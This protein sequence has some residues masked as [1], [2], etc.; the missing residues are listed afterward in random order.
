V[1]HRV[2]REGDLTA[3]GKDLNDASAALRAKARQR[4]TD[5][6]DRPDQIGCD[7]VF[8]L[9]V[10]EF[11]R[12]AEQPVASV[13]DDYVD[14][15]EPGESALDNFANRRSVGHVEHLSVER[16]GVTL[17]QIGNLAGIADSSDDAVAALEELIS[18]LT[19]EAATDSSDEPCALCHCEF[20]V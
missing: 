16:F 8:D 20:S 18:E 7:D 4:G 5:E 19:A 2:P 3:V 9:L 15:S 12:R 6:L 13:A 11:L 14:A 10:A 17:N 1:V